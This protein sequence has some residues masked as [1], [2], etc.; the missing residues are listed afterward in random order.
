[1]K[2]SILYLITALVILSFGACGKKQES[3]QSMDKLHSELGIP[4]RVKEAETST[5]SQSL[6]YNAVLAGA[7]ESTAQA[8]VSDVITEIRAHVGDS[9]KKGDIIVVFPKNTPAAHYDQAESAFQ[10]ISKVHD[11][12]QRLYNES[13]ISLQDY[14]NVRTQY[15]VAKANLEASEQMVYVRA[16][17]SGVITNIMVNVAEKSYPGQSL[18][19][20]A[21]AGGYKATL[22]IPDSE[23][24]KLKRGASVKA[25]WDENSIQGR[26]STI[27][28]AMDTQ[29]KGFRVEVDFPAKHAKIPYGVTAELQVEVLSK[30]NTFVIPRHQLIRENGNSYLWVAEGE[31]ATRRQVEVG[32]ESQLDYEITSGLAAGDLLI[33][34][35]IKSLF[36]GAKIRIIEGS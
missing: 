30:P 18:F 5:F 25:T 14:E 17:I 29:R 7:Q 32:L 4:V 11:R 20:V 35:G 10:S 24:N 33:T 15:L 26:I 3:A 9:V 2:K 13:A 28:M 31:K 22:M 27:A 12:M 1:M 34:E 6:R 19:T 21:G 8:M 16:P 36:E 23:I